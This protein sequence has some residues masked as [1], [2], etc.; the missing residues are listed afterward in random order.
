MALM[1]LVIIIAASSLSFQ[2][3]SPGF[4]N[5]FELYQVTNH[6]TLSQPNRIQALLDAENFVDVLLYTTSAL[7]VRVVNLLSNLPLNLHIIWYKFPGQKTSKWET[8]QVLAGQI[9]LFPKEWGFLSCCKNRYT[10]L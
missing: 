9:S 2:N 1:V 7:K 10:Y 5:P 3:A 6:T 8:E 4:P